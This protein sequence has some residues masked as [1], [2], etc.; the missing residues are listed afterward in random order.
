MD[1]TVTAD[2]IVTAATAVEGDRAARASVSVSARRG[3]AATLERSGSGTAPHSRALRADHARFGKT[4][5]TEHMSEV[6]SVSVGFWFDVGSRDEPPALAGTSH[7]L[8][9]LLFKGTGERSAKDIANIFDSVGG[10][11]NAFT[12]KEY[13]CYYARVLDEDVTMALDVLSDMLT[14]SKVDATELES[15]RKVYPRRDRDARGCA[16]RVGA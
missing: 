1:G 8:E 15:E 14:S 2:E 12:G 6:R 13:T 5:V 3:R 11:V 9:H 16:G 10:E 7:F 4:V